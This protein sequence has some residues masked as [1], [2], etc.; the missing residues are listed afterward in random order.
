MSSSHVK[1]GIDSTSTTSNWKYYDPNDSPSRKGLLLSNEIDRFC[2]QNLLIAGGKYKQENLRPASYTLTIGPDYVD[3]SGKVG[4]LSKKQPFFYI[5]PNSIAYASAAELLDLPYYIAARF[6][7]RVKWVYKGILLGTGPQVE[8]GY[9]GYLSCPLFN[10]TDR[11]I[12]V[13][14][15]EP[16]ATIEFE[17]TSDLPPI[18]WEATRLEKF[19]NV[20]KFEY[21][22]E[23]F[24]LFPQRE[25]PP[26]KHLPDW[27]I[28]SSL[29]QL[30]NEVKT[31]RNI[32]VGLLVAFI[33]LALALLGFQNNLYREL[34][35]TAAEVSA[36]KAELARSSS[37]PVSSGHAQQGEQPKP[38]QPKRQPDTQ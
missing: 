9:K 35:A 17:R 34:R 10:L 6:N 27:D 36:L 12:R 14:L 38:S 15:G 23:P 3:S 21:K 18:N 33:S 16:F 26:L 24:L 32:G 37:S 19:E 25:Y 20:D 1:P 5:E 28:V 8:P 4:K 7:L 31:W 30:S 13:R 22:G 11:A 2:Q 29:V